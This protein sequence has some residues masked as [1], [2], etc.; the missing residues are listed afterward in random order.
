MINLLFLFITYL[1]SPNMDCVYDAKSKESY[2]VLET[3]YGPKIYFSGG[4][5]SDFI[6]ELDGYVGYT[7]LDEVVMIKDSFCDWESDVILIDGEVYDIKK[8]TKVD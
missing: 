2:R 7:N 3:G 1:F 6:L 4:Y 5:G 8:V